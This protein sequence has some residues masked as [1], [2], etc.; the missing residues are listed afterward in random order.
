MIGL[1]F[2]IAILGVVAWFIQT[3]VPM[4]APFKTL[5][6]IICVIVAIFLL[7]NFFGVVGGTPYFGTY[8][9]HVLR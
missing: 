4:A 3:Y 5:F 2:T 1:L 7:L 8:N 6:T 9:N